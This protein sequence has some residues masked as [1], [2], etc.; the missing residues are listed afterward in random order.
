MISY[1]DI[2]LVSAVSGIFYLGYT[3][4]KKRQLHQRLDDL[5]KHLDNYI[6]ITDKD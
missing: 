3:I 1:L 4:T 2:V 6:K 5:K